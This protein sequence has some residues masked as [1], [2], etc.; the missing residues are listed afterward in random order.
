[1]TR[2]EIQRCEAS[3][4]KQRDLEAKNLIYLSRAQWAEEGERS[5]KYF[6]NLMK[7]KSADSTIQ[8][9]KTSTDGEVT[10]QKLIEQEI[11]NFYSQLFNTTNTKKD[12]TLSQLFLSHNVTITAQQKSHMDTPITLIDLYKSVQSCED[13]APGPDAIP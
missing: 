11:H 10:D 8:S 7:S 5:T 12:D 3:I 4:T 1:M 2:L 13:S 9:I 6:L